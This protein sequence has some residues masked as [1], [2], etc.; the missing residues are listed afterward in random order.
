MGKGLVR[1]GVL[2]QGLFRRVR[3]HSGGFCL[4]RFSLPLG[5][6]FRFRGGLN[7]EATF[8]SVPQPCHVLRWE[9]GVGILLYVQAALHTLADLRPLFRGI[10][11]LG[12]CVIFH[13]AQQPLR[14]RKREGRVGKIY[15]TSAYHHGGHVIPLVHERSH[16]LHLL[17][18]QFRFGVEL[19]R[20][21]LFQPFTDYVHLHG[22]EGRVG[23][24]AG[25]HL[26][27][28]ALLDFLPLAV[29]IG[30]HIIRRSLGRF[31]PRHYRRRVNHV[32]DGGGDALGMFQGQLMEGHNLNTG[33][34]N[35]EVRPLKPPAV[36]LPEALLF[37]QGVVIAGVAGLDIEVHEIIHQKD[38]FIVR[39]RGQRSILIQET[40]FFHRFQGPRRHLPEQ[41]HIRVSQEQEGVLLGKFFRG[42]A[43]KQALRLSVRPDS[44][45]VGRKP[46]LF[47]L[48]SPHIVHGYS[49]AL[50]PGQQPLTFLRGADI[51]H[52]TGN[53]LGV[54]P[55]TLRCLDKVTVPDAGGVGVDLHLE[56]Q[57]GVPRLRKPVK[58]FLKV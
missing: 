25:V 1:H 41:A 29:R 54:F 52:F 48:I 37:V 38:G 24:E 11:H 33:L 22:V 6:G 36:V 49:A 31:S 15:R 34:I 35:G 19:G 46:G 12:N 18:G 55:R 58:P 7:D 13:L 23:I 32:H 39:E 2:V 57:G 50:Q 51:D 3:Q 30:R 20:P 16:K 14:I 5:R 53:E 28:P 40:G 9:P 10:E 43:V 21:A 42:L 8:Q 17:P 56:H 27:G 47:P 44:V 4:H 45:A 26:G